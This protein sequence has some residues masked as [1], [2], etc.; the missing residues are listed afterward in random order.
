VGAL[1]AAAVPEPMIPKT[2]VEKRSVYGSRII[3]FD[4]PMLIPLLM[5]MVAKMLHAPCKI[6]PILHSE[7]QYIV[8]T[9]NSLYWDGLRK[10]VKQLDFS[11]MPS[12]AA[13]QLFL[14]EDMQAGADG[15]AWLVCSSTGR[16]G[17]LKFCL[18]DVCTS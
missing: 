2:Q 7:R 6:I 15:R 5:T 16:V 4:D 12:R 8:L 18:I 17:V 9:E 13:K 11:R 1:D 10:E 3:P 14:L